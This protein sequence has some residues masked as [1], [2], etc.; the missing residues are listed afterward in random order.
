MRDRCKTTSNCAKVSLNRVSS[1]D[2]IMTITDGGNTRFL[3]SV[4]NAVVECGFYTLL[5]HPTDVNDSA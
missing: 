3:Q 1:H 5:N 2:Q 4:S